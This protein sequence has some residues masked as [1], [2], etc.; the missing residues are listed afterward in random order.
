M[1]R[2]EK[3]TS[4]VALWAN[5]TSTPHRFGGTEFLYNKKRKLGHIHGNSLLDIPFPMKI[6]NELINSGRVQ[7][8]HVLPE[9]GWVSFYIRSDDDVKEVVE[10][11][12]ISYEIATKK[13]SQQKY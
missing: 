1:T 5:I 11:L 2:S 7:P 8:H 12:R 10:L 3:I 9:S 13:Y 6:R 4:E